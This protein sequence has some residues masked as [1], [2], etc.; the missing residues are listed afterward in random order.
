MTKPVPDRTALLLER[1]AESFPDQTAPLPSI[2]G[3]AHVERRRRRRRNG[4][5]VGAV[6]AMGLSGGLAADQMGLG[7]G[8]ERSTD[9]I[10]DTPRPSC[11][12]NNPVPPSDPIPSGPDYP[13]NAAGQTYGAAIDNSPLPD[14]VA[15]IGDCGRT[16]YVARDRFSEPPPGIPGA[17]SSEPLSVPVYESDGVTQIDTFTQE[18]GKPVA[19]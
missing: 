9:Q 5:L 4:L 10:A 19:P 17:G 13:T 7:S 14:L 3:A 15:A 11:D 16:G 12:K 18:P 1:L 8:S 2:I 6:V